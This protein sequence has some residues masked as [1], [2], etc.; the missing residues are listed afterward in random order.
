M[1]TILATAGHR[2]AIRLD[3]G[4]ANHDAA[5]GAPGLWRQL[6]AL[7]RSAKAFSRNLKRPCGVAI[8]LGTSKMGWIT[9]LKSQQ[10]PPCNTWTTPQTPCGA[11]GPHARQ[12]R[13]ARRP[14][15]RTGKDIGPRPGED[16]VDRT[17]A[18]SD[19][20]FQRGGARADGQDGD[21][22]SLP[23][24]SPTASI[25]SAT[26]PSAWSTRSPTASSISWSAAP[27]CG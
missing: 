4:G 23:E 9:W 2:A 16:C 21:R 6:V 1:A 22:R 13:T 18:R 20:G 7:R 25:P 19:G 15:T 27:T 17:N 3:R 14:S 8:S 5:V 24:A 26:T 11:N 12:S 10:G